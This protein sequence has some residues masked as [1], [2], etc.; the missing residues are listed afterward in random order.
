MSKGSKLCSSF[1]ALDDLADCK[2][3]SV[4][5]GRSPVRCPVHVDGP[6]L[7]NFWKNLDLPLYAGFSGIY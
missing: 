2:L 4:H 3:A 1:R 6:Y 7:T 5:A